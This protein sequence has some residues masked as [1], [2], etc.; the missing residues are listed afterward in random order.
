MADVRAKIVERMTKLANDIA[1]SIASHGL[2]ASGATAR[3]LRVVDSG[4]EIALYGRR[5]FPALETGSARWTGYTG[6]HC[7]F[8]QFVEIIRQ[9]AT[10]KGL[11]F[12][13]A[14]EHERTIRAIAKTIIEKGTKQKRS[15]Q[16]LDVYSDLVDDACAD[17]AEIVGVDLMEQIT[18]DIAKW[19]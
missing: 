1:A 2:A 6:V 11:C 13:Q 5:F 17:M 12:G 18:N 19:R 4:S 7:T 15:G 3:S 9:W 16:R 14:T 8:S 10:A